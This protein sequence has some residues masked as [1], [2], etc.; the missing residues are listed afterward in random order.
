MKALGGPFGVRA[1]AALDAGCD[2]VLHC[3]G[4]MAEM[5]ETATGCGQLTDQAGQRLATA[6][7][8]IT[9]FDSVDIDAEFGRVKELFS[10]FNV[11]LTA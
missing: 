9:D 2:L 11:L 7:S 6:M 1:R 3:S 5:V 4:D 8:L 10:R